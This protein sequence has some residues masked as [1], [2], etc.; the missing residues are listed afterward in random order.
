MTKESDGNV[1]VGVQMN[2]Q[3]G[4]EAKYKNMSVAILIIFMQL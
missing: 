2:E 4:P 3:M 1:W